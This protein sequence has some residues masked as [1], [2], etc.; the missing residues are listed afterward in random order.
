M[1]SMIVCINGKPPNATLPFSM[2][3]FCVISY[4]AT[5]ETDIIGDAPGC[6]VRKQYSSN[7]PSAIA[8]R[9][10]H[11]ALKLTT[12]PFLLA[13]ARF[14]L[15][16]PESHAVPHHATARTSIDVTPTGL[17]LRYPAGRDWSRLTLL[18]ASWI[19]VDNSTRHERHS[20]ADGGRPGEAILAPADGTVIAAWRANLGR[21]RCVA[22]AAYEKGSQFREW[23]HVLL[24]RVRSPR[25]R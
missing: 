9:P 13:L 8:C 7:T 10:R 23:S 2:I 18:Y 14:L 15:G 24:F 25:L 20:G 11:K 17:F 22:D 12:Y 3:V 16:A 6:S 5:G 1:K 19:D 21:G 4:G